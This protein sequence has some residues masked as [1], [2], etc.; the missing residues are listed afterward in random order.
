MLGVAIPRVGLGFMRLRRQCVG[1]MLLV[2]WCVE[3]VLNCRNNAP[4][5]PVLLLPASEFPA[6]KHVRTRQQE[7]ECGMS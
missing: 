4:S 3:H 5:A 2:Q 6:S 7:R 1:G